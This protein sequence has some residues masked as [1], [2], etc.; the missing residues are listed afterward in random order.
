MAVPYGKTKDGFEKQFGT[1]HVV[2]GSRTIHHLTIARL[3]RQASPTSS[4]SSSSKTPCSPP[5]LQTFHLATSQSAPTAI[6]PAQSASTTTS[7]GLRTSTTHGLPTANRRPPT[8]TLR[9]SSNAATAPRV[10]MLPLFIL[11]VSQLVS[12]TTWVR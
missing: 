7:T 3:I 2:S 10:S 4:S 12:R 5:A 8:S 6:V 11:A 1:N 9:T